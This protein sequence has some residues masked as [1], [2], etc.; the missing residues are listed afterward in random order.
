M[1]PVPSKILHVKRNPTRDE[2]YVCVKVGVKFIGSVQ[3]PLISSY[4]LLIGRHSL[5]SF[6]EKE[7]DSIQNLFNLILSFYVD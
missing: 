2:L 3:S 7:F 6:C 1:L 5:C 4:N